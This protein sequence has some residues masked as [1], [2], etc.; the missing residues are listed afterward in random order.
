[1]KNGPTVTS[2]HGLNAPSFSVPR[3]NAPTLNAPRLNAPTLDAP[4]LKLRQAR[5]TQPK[6]RHVVD[7]GDIVLGDIW[8]G[9][10]QLQHTLEDAGLEEFVY[11]PILNRVLGLGLGF[12]ERFARPLL[13]GEMGV[14]RW[15]SKNIPI[16]SR[17]KM[18][19]CIFW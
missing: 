2:Y 12:D 4:G 1:M 11:V 5:P 6:R 10:L 17:C 8:T 9:T 18:K 3:L 14:E 13:K 19:L 7:L 16:Q 15:K